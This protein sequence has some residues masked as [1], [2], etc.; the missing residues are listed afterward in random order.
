MIHLCY[1]VNNAGEVEGMQ[2]A[3]REATTETP[4][5]VRPP[6]SR[7]NRHTRA[8]AADDNEIEAAT[9]AE[10]V[11]LLPS[12]PKT[13]LRGPRCKREEVMRKTARYVYRCQDCGR[14]SIM[15]SDIVKHIT[16]VHPGKTDL[17]S[18]FSKLPRNNALNFP[19]SS[20][21]KKANVVVVPI[22][23]MDRYR[24][25]EEVLVTDGDCL[26]QYM[27]INDTDT[28]DDSL[29][30]SRKPMPKSRKRRSRGSDRKEPVVENEKAVVASTPPPPPPEKSASLKEIQQAAAASENLSEEVKEQMLY[31]QKIASEKH[32][33]K[34]A[35]N[36]KQNPS[37]KCTHCEFSGVREIVMKE[38]I[39]DTHPDQEVALINLKLLKKVKTKH[40]VYFC[41]VRMCSFVSKVRQAVLA[42]YSKVPSHKPEWLKAEEGEGE[43]DADK[44]G[45]ILAG[46]GASLRHCARKSRQQPQEDIAP[47]LDFLYESDLEEKKNAK[48]KKRSKKRKGVDMEKSLVEETPPPAV[49]EEGTIPAQSQPDDAHSEDMAAPEESTTT[50]SEDIANSSVNDTTLETENIKESVPVGKKKKTGKKEKKKKVDLHTTE[51]TDQGSSKKEKKKKVDLNTTE[52]KEVDLNSTEPT[53]HS[54]VRKRRRLRGVQQKT[55]E[56]APAPA[57]QE[58]STSVIAMEG[59]NDGDEKNEEEKNDRENTPEERSD[60]N[61]AE[62]EKSSAE[63]KAIEGLVEKSSDQVDSVP[64]VLEHIP[65]IDEKVEKKKKEKRP[66]RAKKKSIA[67][68]IESLTEGGGEPSKTVNVLD[69]VKDK[70]QVDDENMTNP[71]KSSEKKVEKTATESI[72]TSENVPKSIDGMEENVKEPVK[73]P[74]KKKNQVEETATENIPKPENI[75]QRMENVEETVKEPVKRSKKKKNKVEETKS[76]DIPKP[77]SVPQSVETVEENV[78]QTVEE[79]V[80]QTVKTTRKKKNKVEETVNENSSTSVNEPQSVENM[81]EIATE[82][83]KSSK[84]KKKKAVKQKAGEIAQDLTGVMASSGTE[85][86]EETIQEPVKSPRKKRQ[87][88]TEQSV[89]ESQN[90]AEKFQETTEH[91]MMETQKTAKESVPD[92][93]PTPTKNVSQNDAV[94]VPDETIKSPKEKKKKKAVKQVP[95]EFDDSVTENPLNPAEHLVDLAVEEPVKSPKKKRKRSKPKK[96]EKAPVA[97]PDI[98]QPEPVASVEDLNTKE[99]E[100]VPPQVS[101]DVPAPMPGEIE[102]QIVPD[103][104]ESNVATTESPSESMQQTEDES[105]HENSAE[106]KSNNEAKDATQSEDVTESK[107]ND[108]NKDSIQSEDITDKSTQ[109]E[110]LQPTEPKQLTEEP[111][112]PTER[113]GSVEAPSSCPDLTQE[114][115][116]TEPHLVQSDTIAHENEDTEKACTQDEQPQLNPVQ[117]DVTKATQEEAMD[118]EM[119]SLSKEVGNVHGEIQA[120]PQAQ[121]QEEEVKSPRSSPRKPSPSKEQRMTSPQP[122]TKPRKKERSPK[123]SPDDRSP[124]KGRAKKTSEF[125]AYTVSRFMA[126]DEKVM[127]YKEVV[128][129]GDDKGLEELRG[130]MICRYCPYPSTTNIAEMKCHLEEKHRDAEPMAIDVKMKFQKKSGLIYICMYANCSYNTQKMAAFVDHLTTHKD[131]DLSIIGSMNMAPRPYMTTEPA[132]LPL[133]PLPP[134]EPT[135]PVAITKP[136]RKKPVKPPSTIPAMAPAI[137]PMP[138]VEKYMAPVPYIDNVPITTAQ[139]SRTPSKNRNAAAAKSSPVAKINTENR[140]S[141]RTCKES[142]SDLTRCKAHMLLCH[143]DI[144]HFLVID[145]HMQRVHKR[146]KVFMC[147]QPTCSFVCKDKD[148]IESHVCEIAGHRESEE[149]VGEMMYQCNYCVFTTSSKPGIEEHV[150]TQH[151]EENGYTAIGAQY[152]SN[153]E[154]IMSASKPQGTDED[155]MDTS[156]SDLDTSRE[157]DDDE[158]E[159]VKTFYDM[160]H[161]KISEEPTSNTEKILGEPTINTEKIVSE[162]T[163]NTEKL[164][165]EPTINTEKIASEPTGNKGQSVNEAADTCETNNAGD[166]TSTNIT[167]PTG[168]TEPTANVVEPIDTIEPPTDFSKPMEVTEQTANI[169][170]SMDMARQTAKIT[171]SVDT[172][173]QTANITESVDTTEEAANVAVPM[174]TAEQTANTEPMDTT[175]QAVPEQAQNTGETVAEE[176]KAEERTEQEED[177]DSDSSDSSSSGSDSSSSSSGSSSDSDSDDD[178]EEKEKDAE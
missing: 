158:A 94:K 106:S 12:K 5:V 83:V 162:S 70:P 81:E 143:P 67:S 147:K 42:H 49:E 109:Q 133:P 167:E 96:V 50:P 76:E 101:A 37:Y 175:A 120:Q 149:S 28:E 118:L 146:C 104:A 92:S 168:M 32:K 11:P 91:S 154:F 166:S 16:L 135:T 132:L 61:K 71:V 117:E 8:D 45:G 176:S 159:K 93:I 75:P 80:K 163:V 22:Q 107:S 126:T 102:T 156:R 129:S 125:P 48:G 51:L 87:K 98:F 90:Y 68:V 165:S 128:R 64:P 169:A 144:S 15:K 148:E 123:K 105:P 59:T 23:D 38:H 73:T 124:S 26:M 6:R 173:G 172:A 40:H 13:L 58:E 164:S 130:L 121:V 41:H 63:S 139:R 30:E 29:F 33:E 131:N 21:V 9:A 27:D 14:T 25:L 54:P 47:E 151:G 17:S 24:D 57:V 110:I 153:G 137:A 82:P 122:E 77:E 138:P 116:D 55:E 65:Q 79:N 4:P 18:S 1:R 97:M 160:D 145:S 170:E 46:R 35:A 103:N 2:V 66:K 34:L 39:L 7:R 62:E 84:K 177:S 56:P 10:P 171:E 19:T 136:R 85:N 178:D 155:N 142:F 108:E 69:L 95:S 119:P 157:N 20:A 43:D 36:R 150:K 113:E 161:K 141:C 53:D 60:R 112:L 114:P 72:P 115:M 3:V 86:K 100:V 127:R 74:K 44:E 134:L 78:K 88:V 31:E 140:Y 111:K 152:G 99:S 52:T 174:D 89:E